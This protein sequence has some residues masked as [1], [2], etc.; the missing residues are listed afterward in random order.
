MRSVSKS[1]AVI[2]HFSIDDSPDFNLLF[3]E[4]GR[5]LIKLTN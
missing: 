3:V 1:H 2:A 4:I 5:K